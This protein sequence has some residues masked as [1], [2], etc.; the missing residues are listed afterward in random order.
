MMKLVIIYIALLIGLGMQKGRAQQVTL[1][2]ARQLYFSMD[3]NECNG[4]KLAEQFESAEKITDPILKAYYGASAATAPV[5]VGSPMKKLSW[6][7]KGK[8]LL[9]QSVKSGMTIFE[10]RFLRFATQSKS[11]RFLNYRDNIQEDKKFIL[12]NLSKGENQVKDNQAF[13]S[14]ATFLINSDELNQTEKTIV[15]DYLL[16]KR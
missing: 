1:T 9:D 13:T 16:S 3:K 2:H 4:L 12:D 5:C 14:M 10:I 8:D 6:F 7:N 11:P 15:K